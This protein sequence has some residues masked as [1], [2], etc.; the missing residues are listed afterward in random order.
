L[1]AAARAAGYDDP[2]ITRTFAAQGAG[3]L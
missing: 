3:A 1:R 2:V